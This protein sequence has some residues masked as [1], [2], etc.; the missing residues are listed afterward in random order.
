MGAGTAAERELG[1]AAISRKLSV[2]EKTVRLRIRKM[3]ESG[4]I[5]YYQATP[6]LG[7]FGLK[8][9]EVCRFEAMNVATK[10]G[11]VRYAD[12]LPGTLETF[13]YLGPTFA[14]SVA[15]ASPERAG[16]LANELA[17]HFELKV[18]SLG[19]SPVGEPKSKPDR[20]DWQIIGKLRYDAR[21]SYKEVAQ[22]LSIS[23][24]MAQYRVRKIKDAGGIRIRAVIN[25]QKQEGLVFYELAVTIE[26]ER[27]AAVVRAVRD[28]QGDRLWAVRELPGGVLLLSLFGFTLAEPEEAAMALLAVPGVRWCSILILKEI[29]EP[30]RPNWIDK[31]IEQ[32][33]SLA[34]GA[35]P[36]S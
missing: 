5:K 19:G 21:A 16:Q 7:L 26:P 31:L 36:P 32:K 14:V 2:D 10:Y 4:F 29:L 3:E 20:L 35:A 30:S 12:G 28:A 33:V 6:E 15:S 18:N 27:K 23:Q 22:G 25:P 9:I 13:D 11:A 1:P 17:G 34:R 8:H 24:R